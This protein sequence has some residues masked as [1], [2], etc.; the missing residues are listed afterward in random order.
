MKQK[1]F[2][3]IFIFILL[4]AI[5]GTV[6]YFGS[7][8]GK[9]VTPIQSPIPTATPDVTANWKTY[10]NTA[11]NYSVKYPTNLTIGEN[12]MGGGNIQ[13]AMAVVI[14]DANAKNPESPHFAI[15]IR[16]D[17]DTLVNIANKHYQKL[18]TN[19]LSE[20]DKQK[21]S[22]NL[23][24]TLTDNKATS[25]ITATNFEGY[26]AYQF[27]IAGSVVDDGLSEYSVPAEEHQYIWFEANKK[28]FLISFTKTDTMDQILSTFQFTQ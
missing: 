4:L 23:G 3:Q 16:L 13:K 19:S 6:I 15:T 11:Y 10:S 26:P 7:K 24:Y 14:Y 28:F 2:A 17:N 9:I 1:G 18:T 27:S 21:A 25:A 8:Q 12:G 20:A 22:I 5:L